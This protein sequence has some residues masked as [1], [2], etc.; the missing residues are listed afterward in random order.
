M[1]LPPDSSFTV[2]IHFRPT[3]AAV[4]SMSGIFFSSDH[5]TNLRTTFSAS[6]RA[7]SKGG[8][9]IVQ[10]TAFT[11]STITTCDAP[12]DT[13]V[14]FSNHGCDTLFILSG[15]GPLGSGFTCE[16]LT[17]PIVIPPD[18]S[19]VIHFHFHAPTVGH[20]SVSPHFTTRSANQT[21][22][23]DLQLDGNE[24]PGAA[25]FSLATPAI[26][27]SPL[28]IC[29]EDSADI[30][31]TN[32]GCDTLFVTHDGLAGDPDFSAGSG[33]EERV[34]PGD[35]IHIR[36]RLNPQ[37][38]GARKANY[39][40]SVRSAYTSA[41][42]TT[43]IVTAD[44][45]PGNIL[46]LGSPHSVD[47]DTTTICASPDTTLV[48]RNRGCDTLRIDSATFSRSGFQLFGVTFPI[49]L[50][51]GDS[52]VVGLSTV[53]DTIG[54]QQSSTSVLTVYSNSNLPLAPIA[55]IH[56]YHY[57]F[58]CQLRAVLRTPSATAQD[59]VAIDVIID[60]LPVGLTRI[61]A[62]LQ[63]GNPDLFSYVRTESGNAVKLSNSSISIT[64]SP[65]VAP[66]GV[67]ATIYYAIFLTTDSGADIRFG[68]VRLDS[69]DADFERCVAFAN[70]TGDHF[71]YE[72]YCGHHMIESLLRGDLLLQV[73]NIRPNPATDDL[74]ITVTSGAGSGGSIEIYNVLGVRVSDQPLIL[75][76]G[77]QDVRINVSSLTSGSYLLRIRTPDA[78]VDRSFLKLQ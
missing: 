53:L 12:Q 5:G 78:V 14:T 60:T 36:I 1:I 34:A 26:A 35:T 19:V 75:K 30:I 13:A 69:S 47:F 22:V 21:G 74:D 51:P 64:G 44:V 65:L 18:S 27:F 41:I 68:N 70:G 32:I 8:G 59:T 16:N 28:T 39:R 54:A 58:P 10:Q 3:S 11:F 72:Y 46:L 33:P 38:H 67:L 24:T 52:S 15:P 71:T 48:L 76:S 25:T 4:Y 45:T 77:T 50:P 43:I 57:P 31:Y 6:G 2:T 55:L 62:Q 66:G 56:S 63:T 40:L 23:I 42:D 20:F 9:P 7:F 29:V 61:D 49:I 17:F 73:L 37:Q